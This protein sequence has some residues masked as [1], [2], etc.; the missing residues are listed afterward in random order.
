[1]R[2]F[3]WK[4][5]HLQKQ[6]KPGKPGTKR[7]KYMYFEQML[8]LIPHTPDCTTSSNYSLMTG[9]NGED[10]NERWEDEQ[11]SSGVPS[12]TSTFRKQTAQK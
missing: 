9:S 1:V 10:T 3:F 5:L 4:E 8:F 6:T 11:D 2:D 12:K 7:Q